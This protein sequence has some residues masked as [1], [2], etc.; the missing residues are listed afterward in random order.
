MLLAQTPTDYY[1]WTIESMMWLH[2]CAKQEMFLILIMW[3]NGLY[4]HFI[5]NG[6][7]TTKNFIS[8]YMALGLY[9]SST[10]NNEIGR[11]FD[12]FK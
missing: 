7:K 4:I 10:L 6:W 2:F 12:A 3:H 11:K 9:L 1:L 5:L 8:I